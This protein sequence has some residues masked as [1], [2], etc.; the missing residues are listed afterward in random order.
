MKTIDGLVQGTPAWHAHRAKHFNASDAPA[1]MGLSPYKTRSAL[2]HEMA[3]G[4]TPDIDAGTQK[5][6]DDGHNFEAAAR[7]FAEAIIGDD[8]YPVVGVLEVDGLPLSASF[9][10]ITMDEATAFEHKS[11]NKSLSESL[12]AKVIPDMYKVQMEQQLLIS[13]A[14][15]CLFMASKG[16]EESVHH[17]WYESDPKIREALIAGWKQFR[18]DLAAYKPAASAEPAAVGK[19][20]ETLPALRIEV[21]GMVTASNLAEFKSVAL[22]AIG[23]VNRDLTTDQHFADAEKAVTWCKKVE[24]KLE[25]AKQHALSQTASIDELFRT[26]DDISAEARR[27]R[28]ELDKLVTKRK[29]TIR[30]ELIAS[31]KAELAGFI[32][33]KNKTLGKPYMPAIAEN[34][35]GV[36]KG[37]KTISSIE[38]ALATECA[39]CKIEAGAIADKIHANLQTLAPIM[40]EYPTMFP[41][42]AQVVLKSAEDVTNLVSARVAAHKDAEAKR[43]EAKRQAE[44]AEAKRKADE[45]ARAE[46]TKPVAQQPAAPVN[47]PPITTAPAAPAAMPIAPTVHMVDKNSQHDV[48]T[49]I[50]ETVKELS[51]SEQLQV[52]N[53]AINLRAKQA[54]AA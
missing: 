35:A 16:T 47:Q 13:G 15:K 44:E 45:A 21:T 34:F 20:P 23:S 6:F 29:E 14:Q 27:V 25:G 30:L 39:R 17:Q 5:L 41:D 1:M 2:L 48:I 4:F 38:D 11:L 9:D 26:I 36:I 42:V 19:E 3:T 32:G 7:P 10:G 43:A 49:A 33:A 31:Y 8:L 54:K 46:A 37:K 53:F 24:D 12:Q 18:D 28:L 51:Q 22:A 50:V 40:E 52:L